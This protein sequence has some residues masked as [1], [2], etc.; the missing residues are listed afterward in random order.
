M[1]SSRR[2]LASSVRRGKKEKTNLVKAPSNLFRAT[3]SE[4]WQ[5]IIPWPKTAAATMAVRGVSETRPRAN[6]KT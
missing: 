1:D 2:G 6:F 3:L 5:Q 4:F